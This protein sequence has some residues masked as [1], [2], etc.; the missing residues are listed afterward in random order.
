MTNVDTGILEELG[1][2][3]EV[4]WINETD[5]E[6][7]LI[8]EAVREQ[9]PELAY[10]TRSLNQWT[11]DYSGKSRPG[12]L[13][14]QNKYVAPD[15]IFDEFRLAAE[16][17]R[18]DDIVSNAVETT[19]QLAF[20]RIM[21]ESQNDD[22][23]TIWAQIKDDLNLET[24]MREIW[25]ELFV[26]SQ[27]YVAVLWDRKDYRVKGFT[28]SGKKSKKVYRNLLVP[29]GIT[30]LDPCKVFPVGNFMFNQEELVYIADES[31][32][33]LFHETLAG[34]NSS[35]LIVKQLFLKPYKAS[36]AFI[37]QMQNLTGQY[38]LADRL[39]LLNPENVWRIT[40]TR[41][42]YQMFAD[43]RMRSVF[44]L[45]DMKHNLREMDR[46]D[47]LGNLNAIILVKKGSKERP[48]T[49]NE[50]QQAS[51]QVQNSA[52]IPIIVSDDRMEIEI[53]TRKT[54][55]T[56]RPERYNNLDS[57][58]TSRLFQILSTG[59]YSSGTALDNSTGLFK[60]IAAS[61][62]ARR[63][64]I[65]QAL[66]DNIFDKIYERNDQILD[67]PVMNFYPRRI[68]LEFDPHFAQYVY[69]LFIQGQ[70]SHETALAEIDITL[71]EEAAKKR[72]EEELY[73]DIFDPPRPPGAAGG[74]TGDQKTDGRTGGGNN[75]GGGT[76]QESFNSNP[77]SGSPN[78]EETA[79][80]EE[81][82]AEN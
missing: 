21:V 40:S 20:K 58:I 2:E 28:E 69:D 17:A 13:F 68:A 35:D 51:A 43:V 44:E 79:E 4:L 31:E 81:E 3:S 74:G 52:R 22:E 70:I 55:N 53:I 23:T 57:R 75:N 42:Q 15:N 27:C 6:N 10:L 48:A 33:R 26:V 45:L 50:L 65:R 62:E 80:A 34:L 71:S 59:A 30:L 19:E 61:M 78:E 77:R 12:G 56:L 11:N 64:N 41:P 46:A 36:P 32:A 1:D 60:V 24:R 37:S 38:A 29:K 67:E 8:A 76:N 66:M 7:R 73:D 14:S 49:Q 54:D 16:A 72:K 47:I 9:V 5:V 63:D 18:N 25:R 82:T 39:F